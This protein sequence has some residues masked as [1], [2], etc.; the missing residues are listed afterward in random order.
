M[1]SINR[2]FRQFL[3]YCKYNSEY[4]LIENLI[5]NQTGKKN[6]HGRQGYQVYEPRMDRST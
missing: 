6:R 5:Y 1:E 3:K 4:Y 2:N